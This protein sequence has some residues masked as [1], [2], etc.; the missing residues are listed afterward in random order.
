[1]KATDRRLWPI[2]LLAAVGGLL[3]L[4]GG[5][6]EEAAAPTLAWQADT[7]AIE[8]KVAALCA[9]V[10]GVGEVQVAVTLGASEDGMP[11][12][13][14]IGVVCTGGGDPAVAARLVEL[15]S[16]AFDLGANRICVAPGT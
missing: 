7:A 12:P 2:L 9:E 15:L 8:A 4:F 13:C 3:L 16:A 6:G 11:R 5:R 1:M 14:G 10:A